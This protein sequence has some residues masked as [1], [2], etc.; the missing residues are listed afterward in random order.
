VE[1]PLNRRMDTPPNHAMVQRFD[2]RV[3]TV[4]QIATCPSPIFPLGWILA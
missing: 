4:M 3:V 1:L 2:D